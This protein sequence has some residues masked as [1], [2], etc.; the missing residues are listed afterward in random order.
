MDPAVWIFKWKL[1]PLLVKTG[2]QS[3]VPVMW[4]RVAYRTVLDSGHLIT[5]YLFWKERPYIDITTHN[6]NTYTYDNNF[7][8]GR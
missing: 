2:N 5:L 7:N 8:N 4:T 3:A 6:D 1:S